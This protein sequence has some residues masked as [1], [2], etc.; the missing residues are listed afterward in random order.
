MNSAK[1]SMVFCLLAEALLVACGSPGVPLPPS[2]ELARPVTDL[3][4]VRKGEKVY[5]TWSVPTQTTEKRNIR[6]FGRTQICRTTSAEM[7]ECGIPVA[8]LSPQLSSQLSTASAQRARE[9][10]ASFTDQLPSNMQ[11][12]STSV[13][14]FYA[15]N[16]LNSYG[17]SAGLSNAVQVPGVPTLPPPAD[18]QAQLTG[19]GVHLSWDPIAASPKVPGLRYL[20]R[21]YRHDLESGND[22]IAG[23]LLATDEAAPSL[24]DHSLEWERTYDYRAT[25]VTI[26]TPTNL[27]EQQVEGEDT[28]PVRVFAHDV[29]PPAVPSGLQAVFSGPGQKPFIDLVWAPDTDADLAGYN[30]YRREEGTQ[31]TKINSEPSKSAAFRDSQVSSGH[32]YFYSVSAVDMRGNESAQSEEASETVP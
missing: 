30:V 31:P 32:K 8:E 24:L 15:V 1:G 10:Q 28:A 11:S 4:A 20:Y 14:I 12:P 7:R 17:K 22:V 21:I 26:T 3:R 16:V 23:E 19:E 18:F 9:P 27:A 6:H 5:L 2:L 25:V 13:N 29:F